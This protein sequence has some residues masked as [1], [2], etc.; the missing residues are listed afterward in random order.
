MLGVGSS[1]S[2]ESL[3]GGFVYGANGSGLITPRMWMSPLPSGANT[4]A[5]GG[6]HGHH[7]QQDGAPP[8]GEL[9]LEVPF[10]GSTSQQGQSAQVDVS[11]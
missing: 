10:N 1:H 8:T 3:S 7:H 2:L 4:P 9:G 11:A 6:E 5:R